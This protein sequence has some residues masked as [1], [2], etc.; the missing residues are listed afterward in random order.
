ML[1]VKTKGENLMIKKRISVSQ[2]R[3]ITIPVDF[4]NSVGIDKE[5][6]CYVQNNAIVIRPV[7]ESGG[8]FDE[9]ILADLIAQGLSGQE[10]LDK[11]KETRRQIRPAVERL[12]DEAQRA[13]NGNAPAISYKDIFGS[14]TD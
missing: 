12:L 6:E 3:Q 11:F 13:A 7:R 1:Q 9:Q 4:Y 8:E 5:V 10:L 14:E 2:K